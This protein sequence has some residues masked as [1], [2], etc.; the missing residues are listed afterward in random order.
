MH[1]PLYQ[2]APAAMITP[3]VIVNADMTPTLPFDEYQRPPSTFSFVDM[4]LVSWFSQHYWNN[5]SYSSPI[6]DDSQPVQY[7]V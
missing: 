2:Y 1:G 5:N 4:F 3:S 7:L 6:V